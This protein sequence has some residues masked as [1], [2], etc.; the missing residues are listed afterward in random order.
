MTSVII[1][2]KPYT[3]DIFFENDTTK[4]NDIVN[5]NF[6]K[7]SST[8]FIVNNID[9]Q[10][11][12][13]EG[14]T[15]N[16]YSSLLYILYGIY[17]EVQ[18][19]DLYPSL[20]FFKKDNM[21]DI[22]INQ[23]SDILTD[24][25]ENLL[26]DIN[27]INP[28]KTVSN[29]SYKN[30]NI[31]DSVSKQERNII[32]IYF[33]YSEYTSEYINYDDFKSTVYYENNN[34][35]VFI[36]PFTGYIGKPPT[37]YLY[38]PIFNYKYNFNNT[39]II[40]TLNFDDREDIPFIKKIDFKYFENEEFKKKLDYKSSLLL[41]YSHYMTNNNIFLNKNINSE[42]MLVS[43][44]EIGNLQYNELEHQKE[45]S[46]SD[47]INRNYVSKYKSYSLSNNKYLMSFDAKTNY[48]EKLKNTVLNKYSQYNYEIGINNSIYEFS[49]TYQVNGFIDISEGNLSN[50]EEIFIINQYLRRLYLII[51]PYIIDSNYLENYT[52][53][54][55]NYKESQNKINII[56]SGELKGFIQ[57]PSKINFSNTLYL[58]YY[59]INF[60]FQDY[61]KSINN[62][63][64][65]DNY[66]YTNTIIL[67]IFYYNSQ[68]IL[69]KN[70]NKTTISDDL[71]TIFFE[72]ISKKYS[73]CPSLF[74]FSKLGFYENNLINNYN[75]IKYYNFSLNYD[76]QTK[77]IFENNLISFYNFYWSIP[78]ITT[79]FLNTKIQK[80]NN[81]IENIISL[82][83]NFN[84]LLT[85]NL[86]NSL[87][88]SFVIDKTI[89]EELISEITIQNNYVDFC[90]KKFQ[91]L[92]VIPDGKYIVFKYTNFFPIHKIN[93]CDN[94]NSTCQQ[95][96]D[97]YVSNIN[98]TE[99]FINN[100]FSLFIKIPSRYSIKSSETT[101]YLVMNYYKGN[102]Y[103]YEIEQDK[104][105]YLGFELF[106]YYYHNTSSISLKYIKNMFQTNYTKMNTFN[107]IMPFYKYYE[108]KNNI[109][110]DIDNTFF[111]LHNPLN[112][113]KI[114]KYDN[115]RFLNN[116]LK[117]N[118]YN[119]VLEEGNY[120]IFIDNDIIY[121][122]YNKNY[123][124][125]KTIIKNIFQYDLA[126]II[127]NN[128]LIKNNLET[129]YKR[130]LFISY[131][132]K[133]IQLLKK[134]YYYL[135][136]LKINKI[137]G[138][139][140]NKNYID[141]IINNI[142]IVLNYTSFN[143]NLNITNSVTSSQVLNIF[144]E[145]SNINK[146]YNLA[147]I[148]SLENNILFTITYEN[149]KF[150]IVLKEIYNF[151]YENEKINSF[152]DN[153]YFL[154]IRKEMND[155][156]KNIE[157]NKYFYD[158]FETEI[159]NF[160][161]KISENDIE[162][163]G[164][165]DINRDGLDKTENYHKVYLD[166][167]NIIQKNMLTETPFC[168]N[169]YS[170]Y[171][172]EYFKT[173]FNIIFQQTSQINNIYNLFPSTNITLYIQ[174]FI[175]CF[176]K[177]IQI[178]G[179]QILIENI[180]QVIEYLKQISNSFIIMNNIIYDVVEE[181]YN[182]SGTYENTDI[183]NQQAIIVFN[184]INSLLN[185]LNIIVEVLE[186]NSFN[187]FYGYIQCIN[188]SILEYIETTNI[189]KS[190][191]ENFYIQT[192][193][194]LIRILQILEDDF[195]TFYF[196][197]NIILKVIQ[198]YIK[199]NI[200]K[201]LLEYLQETIQLF[202]EQ[203]N[204]KFQQIFD[205]LSLQLETKI[206][207]YKELIDTLGNYTNDNIFYITLVNKYFCKTDILNINPPIINIKNTIDAS[208]NDFDDFYNN[209]INNETTIKDI[210]NY[211]YITNKYKKINIT[212][213]NLI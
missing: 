97:I 67:K 169:N 192:E 155:I 93:T 162:I 7:S 86:T 168:E 42:N 137:L 148:N 119:I 45:N 142:K 100:E 73:I 208:E 157:K 108:E 26:K 60:N 184:I 70:L 43:L 133:I 49:R 94:D 203:T 187:C 191:I 79:T 195:L 61:L 59:T 77:Y 103:L 35:N 172:K 92:N 9:Y 36:Y 130:I 47:L 138:S 83:D 34:W 121:S 134:C 165:V 166:I 39:N 80:I 124:Q 209:F 88:L 164:I 44:N 19:T 204:G 5:D 95:E 13:L 115:G 22:N 106:N 102:P 8:I 151:I 188:N 82:N 68:N 161:N 201:T 110:Y 21:R 12:N 114:I 74:N 140:D 185:Y 90:G 210:L 30:I 112:I 58:N 71:A 98:S 196:F 37:S 118:I 33:N 122:G 147:M 127:Y 131:T 206:D 182:I 78:N 24:Y 85:K 38:N 1:D 128:N 141:Y 153:Y 120:Q 64:S 149:E 17:P 41:G 158:N 105:V 55:I 170:H 109:N 202:N 29:F 174:L 48:S 81:F 113:D 198:I 75:D 52:N 205:S 139:I 156:I 3:P 135:L 99:K 91:N 177:F 143:Y 16:L 176:E 23:S 212:N 10:I 175:E 87:L 207:L 111:E 183:L 173:Y 126:T 66:D 107:I 51:N 50:F 25:L 57:Y 96:N 27:Y 136:L 62:D 123:I 117:N 132:I 72:Q 15:Y 199:G 4:T 200:T 28:N 171:I 180:K 76:N 54:E 159:N 6:I 14:E 186:N 152:Y 181:N 194:K 125:K 69:I 40:Q 89:E 178:S 193:N 211:N 150:E 32:F 160:T 56:N 163:I 20:Y 65:T 129:N 144:N 63:N 116:V 84:S 146:T 104:F 179:D 197:M 101:I 53:F 2:N 190:L 31:Y 18:N 167:E 213:T 145:I 11:T 189:R 46:I 154:I